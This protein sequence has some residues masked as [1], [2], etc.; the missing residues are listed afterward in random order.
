M[1]K[2]LQT[3]NDQNLAS[4]DETPNDSGNRSASRARR[5]KKKLSVAISNS[6]LSDPE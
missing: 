2:E 1:Q 6:I 4:I 5:R 3:Y